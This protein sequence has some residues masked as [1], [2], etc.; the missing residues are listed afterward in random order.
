VTKEERRFFLLVAAGVLALIVFLVAFPRGRETA[1]APS[2]P[3]VTAPEPSAAA[4]A[5]RGWTF[6]DLAATDVAVSIRESDYGFPALESIHLIGV[7][8]FFG[9]ILMLD[10]RLLGFA[11]Q[12]PIRRVGRLFLPLT[13]IG[14]AAQVASGALLFVAYADQLVRTW[15][16]PIKMGLILI[17]GINMLAFHW[18]TWRTV[19]RWDRERRTATGAKVAA[20]MSIAVWFAAIV[21]GRWA[22]YERRPVLDAPPPPVPVA[23][24]PGQPARVLY[25]YEFADGMNFH[26]SVAATAGADELQ[27][28]ANEACGARDTCNVYVWEVFSDYAAYRLAYLRDR[29]AGADRTMWDCTRYP[30]PNRDA[31]IPN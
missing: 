23:A 27:R 19:D 31:C 11:P 7:A 8:L 17:G 22:G 2:P 29:P 20:V 18:T 12:L 24:A 6:D 28:L 1:T 30:Q 14:F 15:S 5:R 21:A 9:S 13:W 16:F 10:L 3:V 26:L 25:K 4:P